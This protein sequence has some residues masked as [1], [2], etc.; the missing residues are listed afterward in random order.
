MKKLRCFR[1]RLFFLLTVPAQTLAYAPNFIYGDG[2]T[3]TRFAINYGGGLKNFP[4]GLHFDVRSH[5]IPS[6]KVS[7][8]TNI[9]SQPLNM[10]EASAGVITY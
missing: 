5:A 3:G 6:A 7:S 4:A 8:P 10:I 1:S 2:D 9:Q